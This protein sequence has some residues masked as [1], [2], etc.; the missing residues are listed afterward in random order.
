MFLLAFLVALGNSHSLKINNLVTRP[1]SGSYVL[2]HSGTYG[3]T[4]WVKQGPYSP[5]SFTN[6]PTAVYHS[7]GIDYQTLDLPEASLAYDTT[8]WTNCGNGIPV[9]SFQLNVGGSTRTW[10]SNNEHAWCFGTR[11]SMAHYWNS[12][13]ENAPGTGTM[14]GMDQIDET[15]NWFYFDDEDVPH[16]WQAISTPSCSS[17]Y[18]LRTDGS[19]FSG[20]Y[21]ITAHWQTCVGGCILYAREAEI[22]DD[23]C[24]GG[25]VCLHQLNREF[26]RR[27]LEGQDE[28][29]HD[30][31]AD[32]AALKALSS[33]EIVDLIMSAYDQYDEDLVLTE[34][35][36]YVC[37]GE[38]S[39]FDRE[40]S[41]FTD[42]TSCEE[43]G[44]NIFSDGICDWVMAPDTA[45]EENPAS[46]DSN[47]SSGRLLRRR[48]L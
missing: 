41:E 40:C 10:G 11:D 39:S 1:N 33:P 18:T 25:N 13:S 35:D 42:Q 19:V 44:V 46:D 8:I 12:Q 48:K 37:V 38:L 21:D 24:Y 16:H 31:D 14:P 15:E 23:H 4:V 36:D 3:C 43:Q 6:I 22:S 5:V 34:S 27:T 20:N 2:P 32:V 30:F 17:Y 47:A 26:D 29:E 45:E 7:N 28:E 9:N